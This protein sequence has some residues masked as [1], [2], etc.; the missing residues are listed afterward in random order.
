MP[1]LA[2]VEAY[3]RVAERA[4]HR[5]VAAVAARDEWFIRRTPG[6][7]ALAALLRGSTFVE[8]RRRGKLLVLD[9]DSG[10]ALGMR[11]GMTG[12][13]VVD[14]VA[15][16]DELLYSSTRDDPAFIRFGV[17][18]ADGGDLQMSDPRRL[19]SV[20]LDPTFDDLGPDALTVTRVELTD[21]LAGSSVALKARLMDQRRVAGV[22]NL[23]ADEV[24]WRAAL[25]PVRPSSQLTDEEIG[26]LARE[27]RSTLRMMI[28]RGGSHTGDLMAARVRGG[29]CPRDGAPL[30]RETVGGRTTYWCPQH[31]T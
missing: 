7:A 16:V 21:A 26:R 5:P 31:Q 18:F 25:S 17:T 6:A 15:G 30:R 12:R 20:E 28:R 29:A 23:T 27:V 11:F 14:G 8:A 24:L 22:G 4:L 10:T 3:R 9:T 19:G 13:L 2:E 1:E